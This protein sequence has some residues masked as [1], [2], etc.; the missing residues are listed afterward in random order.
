MPKMEK[1]ST[2][3]FK[4]IVENRKLIASL[5]KN[6]FKTKFAGSYLGIVWAFVQPVVTVLLYWFV[7]EVAMPQRALGRGSL[8]VPFVLWL[9]AGLIPWFFFSDCLGGGTAVLNEYN[10]LVKKVVFNIDI[11]PVVKICSSMFVHLFFVAFGMLIFACMGFY[12]NLYYLQVIYYSFCIVVLVLGLTYLTSAVNVFFPDLRQVVNIALQI[13]IWMT[14]I[15]WNLEDMAANIPKA[16]LVILKANPMYYIVC[17]FRDSLTTGVGFWEKPVLTI[18]FWIVT[19]VIFA[20][21]T[22]V[23]KRLKVHFADVL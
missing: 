18:Y 10:Y 13:G 2:N 6:D 3:I 8:S 23:F 9:I 1:Q 14:P 16:V 22:T 7:F 17:G 19:I 15:M 21:G 12:P 5:A 11:L 4:E 20:L